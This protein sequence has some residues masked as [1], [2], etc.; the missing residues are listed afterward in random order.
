MANIQT[1]IEDIYSVLEDG[2]DVN[3]VQNRDALDRFSKNIYSAVRRQLGEGTKHR[4]SEEPRIRMS[5]IGK[6][7]RQ[8]WYEFN[9]TGEPEVL[10]G[11]SKMRFIFGD[12]LEALLILLS[13]VSGHEVTECQEEVTLEGIKGHKDC[14]IDGVLTDIKSASPYSFKKFKEGTLHSSDAFGYIAQISAYAEASGSK[15]AKFFAVDK[16][17]GEM[18][19]MD[20][21]PVHMINA[22]E[23]IKRV[24]NMVKS[25]VTPPRCYEE[26]ADGTSGNMKLPVGCVFCPHKF[27]CWKTSNQGMGLRVFQYSNGNRFLTQ[28]HKIPN[29]PEITNEFTDAKTQ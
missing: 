17:S 14:R 19:L 11:Q 2:V 26:E 3:K 12:M 18:A 13:E 21:Q 24:K 9:T 1:L 29:V 5:Q 27:E 28:V 16:S 25:S 15:D 23:R 4:A 7:D 22:S 20:V 8:L 6:P 10:S